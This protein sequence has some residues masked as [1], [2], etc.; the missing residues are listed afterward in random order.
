M[1]VQVQKKFWGFF[2]PLQNWRILPIMWFDIMRNYGRVKF[3]DLK[4][5]ITQQLDTFPYTI[6]KQFQ[7]TEGEFYFLVDHE[8]SELNIRFYFQSAGMLDIA[9]PIRK[10]STAEVE[11]WIHYWLAMLQLFL[12]IWPL[13]RNWIESQFLYLLCM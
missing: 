8:K 4:N 9:K 7:K 6:T 5:S 11:Y 2:F 13:I 10:N 3:D 12:I 1:R